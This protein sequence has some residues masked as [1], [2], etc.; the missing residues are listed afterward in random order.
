MRLAR[1]CRLGDVVECEARQG[2]RQESE[3][4]IRKKREKV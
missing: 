2:A 4:E 1:R 3:R